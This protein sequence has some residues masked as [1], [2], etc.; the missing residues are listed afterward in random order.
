MAESIRF[1][2]GQICPV[3]IKGAGGGLS[4][5]PNGDMLLIG[6]IASPSEAQIKT[7]SE[8]WRAKLVEESEFPSIPIFAIGEGEDWIL[9]A[10]CNPGA[11]ENEAPGFCEALYAKEEY[12]MAA[13]LV[14]EETGIIKKISQVELDEIFIER[15]VMAWNPYRFPGGSN[16]TEYSRAFNDQ[17]FTKKIGEIFKTRSSQE[18]WRT[19]Y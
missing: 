10:P 15:L 7:W 6:A 11:I 17:E 9:E 3:R 2:E 12:T 18:L 4:F 14:D 19:S 1:E 13:V 5:S 16:G 8:P